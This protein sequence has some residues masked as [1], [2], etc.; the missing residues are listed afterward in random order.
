[1]KSFPMNPRRILLLALAG[2]SGCAD[3]AEAPVL[4]EIPSPAAPGSGEPNLATGPD[5]K[6]YLTW[7]EPA[8]DS[9]HALRWSALD[10]AQ[11]TA[12]RT[13][14][15][16]RD[17]FVNWADF[18]ALAVLPGGSMAAHWLQRSGPGTYA[19]DVRVARSA[20]GGRSWTPGVVP[21]GDGRQA[22]HG[23]VAMWPGAGD[24]VGLV[25]LDG[26]DNEGKEEDDPTAQTQ[27]RAGMVSLSAGA[28]P[29]VQLDPRTCDCCQNAV[30][31]T[32]EGPLVVYRDR[33]ADEIRDIYSVR[34]SGG[35]WSE[36]RAVHA[37]GW[38]I[39]ACPVNGPS[40][41]ADGRRVAVAWFTAA[42]SLP[43]VRLAFSDDAGE[44]WSAPIRVDSTG[45]AGR[46]AAG[47]VDVELLADGALVTWLEQVPGGAEIRARRVGHDGAL[48][49]PRT[50][51]ASSAAR[52]SGFPRM[53][54]HGDDMIFAWTL[55][56][57]PARLHTARLPL[58]GL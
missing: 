35:R 19:Y 58:E 30:A 45:T 48:G 28:A 27:L 29:D 20:D 31:L 11:W 15:T 24:S 37:D 34:W 13:I 55:P 56:G 7:I 42:D 46:V 38:R 54:R 52:S 12:P 43:R 36:P 14:A 51:A 26:R 18:P 32:A 25:W 17:W 1:M 50:I 57:S 21:H 40:V 16:G 44:H 23:F 33:T 8:A 47:R 6:V 4:T 10:G 22:E 39:A 49:E 53:A 41:M 2:S 9:A 3:R 5:G